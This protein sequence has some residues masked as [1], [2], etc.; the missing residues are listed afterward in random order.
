MGNPLLNLAAALGQTPSGASVSSAS[1]GFAVKKRWD[2][3]E[4]ISLTEE[5]MSDIGTFLLRRNLQEPSC[6][7]RQIWGTVCQ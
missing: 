3:G 7:Q 4:L 6:H 1:G 2:D 5:V